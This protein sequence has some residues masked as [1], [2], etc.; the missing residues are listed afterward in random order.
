MSSL[1]PLAPG[2]PA[3]L[4][5]TVDRNLH[6][7]RGSRGIFVD[8]CNSEDAQL[9]DTAEGRLLNTQPYSIYI[10][11]EVMPWQ[12]AAGLPSGVYPL[13]AVR[14]TWVLHKQTG[15]KVRRKGFCVVPDF[16][17]TAHMIQGQSLDGLSCD[18]GLA[19]KKKK[20]PSELEHL[21]AY[22]MLSRARSLESMYILQPFSPALFQTGPPVGA[23]V[24]LRHMDSQER[25]PES[26][27]VLW[28]QAEQGK[29]QRRF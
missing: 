9:L 16:A 23:H 1:V 2:M 18:L 14:R 28:A 4:T 24:L 7:Y 19:T 25:D 15:A 27:Q 3:R 6:L 12:F 11:F 20:P 5:D 26:L 10:Q 17:A 8:W 13:Q 29:A 21:A 22:V